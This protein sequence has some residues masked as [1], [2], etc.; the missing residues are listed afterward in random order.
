VDKWYSDQAQRLQATPFQ[1]RLAMIDDT[2]G[3][4]RIRRGTL[5]GISIYAIQRDPRSWDPDAHSYQPIRFYDK[6]IVA[7]RPSA[8][9]A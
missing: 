8:G 5:I 7:A 1:P 4:Y 9:K 3:G 6:D 2:V